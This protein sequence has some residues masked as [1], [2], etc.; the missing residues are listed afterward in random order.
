MYWLFI[1]VNA[2]LLNMIEYTVH[3]LSH[4]PK[5]KFLYNSHHSHHLSYP[6]KKLTCEKYDK[7]VEDTRLP[8]LI[9]I[10]ISYLFCYY[11]FTLYHFLIFISETTIYFFIANTLHNS[12]HLD[13][14]F[15]ERFQWFRYL[16]RLHHIH[17]IEVYHNLNITIPIS[18]KI[19]HTLSENTKSRYLK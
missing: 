8:Y 11:L 15:L 19:N 1:G 13:N 14:S 4:N 12:Y 10:F 5:I 17:H 6:P 2:L 16:K 9:I 7:N 18:D 3:C